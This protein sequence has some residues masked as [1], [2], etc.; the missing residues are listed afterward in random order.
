MQHVLSTGRSALRRDATG[1]A[2]AMLFV[3]IGLGTGK[4]GNVRTQT[5]RAFSAAD[6]KNVSD[7]IIAVF[8]SEHGWRTFL[9][10]LG[11]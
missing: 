1:L 4:L 11:Q 2:G 3:A 10:R 8:P 9:K 5:L 6:M 7:A